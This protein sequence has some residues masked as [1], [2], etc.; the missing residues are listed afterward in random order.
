VRNKQPPPARNSHRNTTGQAGKPDVLPTVIFAR[1]LAGQL[2]QMYCMNTRALAVRNGHSIQTKLVQPW[3]WSRTDDSCAILLRYG[4][5]GFPGHPQL[6]ERDNR[7][8]RYKP[9]NWH[10]RRR[11][12]DRYPRRYARLTRTTPRTGC[13]AGTRHD[14]AFHET[15]VQ[16]E[17]YQMR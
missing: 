11:W 6:Y 7:L 14:S 1:C 17:W 10:R 16:S 5:T 4:N 3:R 12:S 9:R 2:A 13:R 8:S 15:S